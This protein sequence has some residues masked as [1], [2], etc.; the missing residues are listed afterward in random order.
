[1]NLNILIHEELFDHPFIAQHKTQLQAF[2]KSMKAPACELQKI[3]GIFTL[4]HPKMTGQKPMTSI[5]LVQAWHQR[6]RSFRGKKEP[7]ARAFGLHKRS[8]SR[9]ILDTTA[10]LGRDSIVLAKLGPSVTM[11]ERELPLA[12]LLD[13][14]LTFAQQEPW[15]S[16]LAPRISLHYGE[17]LQYCLTPATEMNSLQLFSGFYCDPMF[18]HKKNKSASNKRLMQTLQSL[19]SRDEQQPLPTQLLQQLSPNQR[20]VIKR[21]PQETALPQALIYQVQGKAFR[22]D[23]HFQPK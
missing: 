15:F 18:E 19:C 12:C 8:L 3:N 4:S 5:D 23:V 6:S 17:A 1:M 10:G 11:I 20:L 16:D 7:L 13:Q 22:F 2:A 9:P 21:A 14:A